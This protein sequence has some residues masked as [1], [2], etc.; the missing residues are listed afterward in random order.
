MRRHYLVFFSIACAT[1]LA[2]ADVPPCKKVPTA[3]NDSLSPDAGPRVEE[4]LKDIV[5]LG[6]GAKGETF[7][8]T[9]TDGKRY[10][11][12]KARYSKSLE[13][14]AGVA[15]VAGR[16]GVGPKTE[17]LG[18]RGLMRM[19]LLEGAMDLPTFQQSAVYRL[20]TP[21]ERETWT[22]NFLADANKKL[23]ALHKAG[24]VHFDIKP[25]NLLI[26]PKAR[27]GSHLRPEI[28]IIDYG[29]AFSTKEME[30]YNS[31]KPA[32][33]EH[34]E[35]HF[36]PLYADKN[37]AQQSGLSSSQDQY[38]LL[39]IVE[40]LFAPPG[41]AT[42]NGPHWLA[43]AGVRPPSTW[44]EAQPPL[45]AKSPELQAMRALLN[46]PA[47]PKTQNPNVDELLRLATVDPKSAEAAT[48]KKSFWQLMKGEVAAMPAQDLV[49]VAF[50]SPE[51]LKALETSNPQ[52]PD[53]LLAGLKENLP[54][55][56]T[57]WE[58]NFDRK[59]DAPIRNLGFTNSP[60]D[61]QFT[62]VTDYLKKL[63]T[64]GWVKPPSPPTPPPFEGPQASATNIAF[65]AEDLAK[66]LASPPIR[67][68]IERVRA[69]Q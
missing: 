26:L 3:V 2:F 20:M 21:A 8:A 40:D 7:L 69:P 24:Y 43:N 60:Y 10:V 35:V 14:E 17:Y 44:G 5:P 42:L 39:R 9:D 67:E 46:H 63:P 57:L 58:K 13:H 11:F 34:L 66:Y 6:G 36:T 23:Q 49:Q 19:E 30:A 55:Y 51:V 53:V 50:T 29:G 59:A 62:L 54:G 1:P 48:S 41:Q 33:R 4:G 16:I 45:F 52:L 12:K 15:R 18:E 68:R 38:A 64:K 61:I 47:K 28:K 56:Q 65:Y 37:L 25:E 31:A 32:D 22:R 27:G